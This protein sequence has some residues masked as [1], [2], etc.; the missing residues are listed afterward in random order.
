MAK[1]CHKFREAPKL[2][3][4]VI[5]CKWS[6]QGT[7][8]DTR[9]PLMSGTLIFKNPPYSQVTHLRKMHMHLSRCSC[10]MSHVFHYLRDHRAQK[11]MSEAVLAHLI[12]FSHNLTQLSNKAFVARIG[13]T[14]DR[15]AP[16]HG[17]RK[18]ELFKHPSMSIS[19][20]CITPSQC[21]G[22]VG[23][24]LAHSARFQVFCW[25]FE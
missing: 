13:V 17:L 12:I 9:A 19:Y 18:R 3:Y 14:A 1:S 22:I 10:V 8:R 2:W 24:W 5:A 6:S 20:S 23:L 7:A 25:R 11:C 21:C 16:G 4:L 15:L